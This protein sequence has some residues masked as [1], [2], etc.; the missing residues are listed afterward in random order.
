MELYYYFIQVFV[1]IL[2]YVT[3]IIAGRYLIDKIKGSSFR[4][5]NPEEYLPDEE[6]KTLKQVFYLIMMLILFIIIINF[7]F[8]NNIILSNGPEF[9]TFHSVLDIIISVY[10]ASIIYDKSSQ[11]NYMLILFLFPLASIAFLL[12]GESLLEYWDF[13]RIPAL[14]YLMKYFYENFKSYTDRN[15]LSFSIILLFAIL[16][17]SIVITMF[18]ENE[19]PLNAMVMVSNA[20]TSNG[21][22]ILGDTTGGKINSIVLVWSGYILSGV[23][24][25]TLTTTMIIR[26]YKSRFD[27]Y[28]KKIDELHELIKELKNE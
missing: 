12:F 15:E 20:Y 3:L 27:N 11:K 24:T 9:Y 13:V 7:F 26:H 22:A 23:A 25:A 4:F 19:D 17:L 10:I 1:S 18:I 14:A 5:L 16:F 21:Y 6:I 2:I 8:D 28:D